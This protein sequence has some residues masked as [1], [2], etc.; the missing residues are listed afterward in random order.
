MRERERERKKRTREW[1]IG[2]S[3]RQSWLKNRKEA[4]MRQVSSD[5][6]GQQLVLLFCS[7]QGDRIRRIFT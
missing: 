4:A 2:P 7:E 1:E 5:Q 3:D 6:I